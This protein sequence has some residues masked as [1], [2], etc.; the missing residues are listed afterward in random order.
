MGRSV[1]RFRQFE[2][3]QDRCAMKVTTL[4]CILGAW[5]RHPAPRR[6]LDIGTG[7]GLLALMLAQRY[8]VPVDA[9]EIDPEAC[10]QAAANVAGSPWSGRVRVI[11]ADIRQYAAEAGLYYDFIVSNPPFYAR[12]LRTGDP[13]ADLA[14]HDS[15]LTPAELAGAVQRLLHPEGIF[16]VLMP[17]DGSRHLEGQMALRGLLPAGMLTVRHREGAAPKAL[18]CSYRRN[19]AGTTESELIIRR[20]DEGYTEAYRALTGEYYPFS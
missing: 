14:R 17:P 4:A 9:V 20:T 3:R 11:C 19:P 5:A 12:Q 1:F 15:G 2:L 8:E 7:T 16:C 10:S 6:I 18:V 13:R